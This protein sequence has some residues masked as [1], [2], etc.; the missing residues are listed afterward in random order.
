[1]SSYNKT[2]ANTAVQF[3]K[4]VVKLH[5]LNTKQ[6]YTERKRLSNLRKAVFQNLTYASIAGK[7]GTNNGL[8]CKKTLPLYESEKPLC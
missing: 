1:M 6:A 5:F 8:S 2:A 3:L 7:M 4:R